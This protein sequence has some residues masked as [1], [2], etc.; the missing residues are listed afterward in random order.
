MPNSIDEAEKIIDEMKI[1][2]DLEVQDVVLSNR[3]VAKKQT[4]KSVKET[5]K[6][7]LNTKIDKLI[8]DRVAELRT[9]L[10]TDKI[11]DGFELTKKADRTVDKDNRRTI[12]D[13]KTIQSKLLDIRYLENADDSQDSSEADENTAYTAIEEL[14]KKF[15][16]SY[17]S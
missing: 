6:S 9:A 12:N 17:M 8:T 2:K 10:A 3:E 11:T 7:G 16:G 4:E 5:E 1:T 14:V 15:D 13:L